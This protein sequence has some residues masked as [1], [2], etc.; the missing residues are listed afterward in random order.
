M[1]YNLLDIVNDS[2]HNG[3]GFVEIS[4]LFE[5]T[6]AYFFGE[7]LSDVGYLHG[8]QVC[9]FPCSLHIWHDANNVK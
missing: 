8:M 4:E 7:E 2:E 1:G 3:V 5:M 6:D 9:D